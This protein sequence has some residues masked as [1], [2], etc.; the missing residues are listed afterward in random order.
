MT[1]KSLFIR[2]LY[3]AKYQRWVGRVAIFGYW[4]AVW[5]A[6]PIS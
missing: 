2:N 6:L 1:K 3:S 5:N 4:V